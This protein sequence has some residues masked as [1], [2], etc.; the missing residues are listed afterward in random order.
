MAFALPLELFGCD[1]PP[2]IEEMA[3]ARA[4]VKLGSAA[5]AAVVALRVSLN[6]G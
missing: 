1:V 2:M 3:A 6:N 4:V 5:I